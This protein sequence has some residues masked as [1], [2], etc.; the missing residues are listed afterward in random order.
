MGIGWKGNKEI[1]SKIDMDKLCKGC[2][3]HETH[4]YNSYYNK[5]GGYTIKDIGCPCINCLVKVMCTK[6]CEELYKRPWWAEHHKLY[7][8]KRFKWV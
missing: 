7:I 6:A 5:C 1:M 2:T 3:I 4:I 8:P